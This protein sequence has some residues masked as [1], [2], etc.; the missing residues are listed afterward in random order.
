M[1]Y[2]NSIQVNYYSIK[3]VREPKTTVHDYHLLVI[4]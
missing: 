4:R 2:K 1:D 3:S